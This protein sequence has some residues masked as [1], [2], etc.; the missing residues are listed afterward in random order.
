MGLNKYKP[1]L[2]VLP[3]DDPN[4]QI[5]NGFILNPALNERTIQVLPVIG[6]WKKV[7]DKFKAVHV[8]EMHKY[9]ERRMLLMV[10]FD[11]QK[12][13]LSQIR[14]G[15]PSQLIDRVFILGTLSEPEY[16]KTNLKKS[17]EDIGNALSQDCV[18]NTRTMWEHDL[19]KHNR[20]ELDR[21]ILAVK[22]FLFD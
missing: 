13:R 20:T 4:R 17:Y 9:P 6:G 15:I 8:H 22:P 2:Y 14:N 11:R 5:V 18:D 21:M 12:K 19:L 1:H 16:L 7:V 10:D 3:E